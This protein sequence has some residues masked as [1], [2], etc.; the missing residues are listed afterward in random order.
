MPK[1]HPPPEKSLSAPNPGRKESDAERK[2]IKEMWDQYE[3]NA[4]L[5]SDQGRKLAYAIAGVCWGVLGFFENEAAT[6]SPLIY[7]ALGMSFLF[8]GLDIFQYY[9][10]TQDIARRAYRLEAEVEE[11][12]VETN[13]ADR[14]IAKPASLFYWTFRA[15]RYKFAV[16]HL[17]VAMLILGLLPNLSL[18]GMIAGFGVGWAVAYAWRMVRP[19]MRAR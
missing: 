16:L 13:S 19:R 8:I 6:S 9:R 18:S 14:E 7:G 1:D 12:T 4:R 11:N 10:S 15:Y 2:E 17:G 5:A 3:V